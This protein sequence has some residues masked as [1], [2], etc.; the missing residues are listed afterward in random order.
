ML[1]KFDDADNDAVRN[2]SP[3]LDPSR[4]TGIN[5]EHPMIK[6]L[7]SVPRIYLEDA[8]KKLEKS[9]SVTS[10]NVQELDDIVKQ[11]EALGLDIFGQNEVEMYFRDDP[12]GDLVVAVQTVRE[13]YTISET[14]NQESVLNLDID[15]NLSQKQE[16]T[17]EQIRLLQEQLG[18]N[19]IEYIYAYNDDGELVPIPVP[20]DTSL[21]QAVVD[22]NAEATGTK[23]LVEPYIYR[24]NQGN[25]ERIY[26]YQ[27][28]VIDTIT[29]PERNYFNIKHKSLTIEFIN[30]INLPH[31]YLV[32]IND[33][34]RIKINLHNPTVR[35]NFNFQ[36]M[37]ETLNGS[38]ATNIYEK[39][40]LKALYFLRDVM[41]DVFTEIILNNE[42]LNNKITLTDST[43][44]TAKK[45]LEHR[46]DV[47]TRI[48][49]SMFS[50]FATYISA[51]EAMIKVD[52]DATITAAKNQM[53]ALIAQGAS[54]EELEAGAQL[55][56]DTVYN[57]VMSVL[58]S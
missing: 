38:Y 37:A 45:I 39:S 1:K 49:V 2:P 5:E 51:R 19:N 12:E 13:E 35:D 31:R 17:E 41:C 58:Q 36:K 4:I 6:S 52:V 14:N 42:I 7:Y 54:D 3:I 22:Y 25:L 21:T 57:N 53:I 30:D 29:D 55:A 10:I 56:A 34:I 8:I 44:I 48:E 28:G 32:D 9:V 26:I 50:L 27:K 40:S 46:K 33:G 18:G 20:Q 16:L 11:L 15:T 47:M 24:M 23:V 43:V